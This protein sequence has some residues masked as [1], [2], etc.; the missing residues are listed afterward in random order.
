MK[1]RLSQ[2]ATL[3]GPIEKTAKK[4]YRVIKTK[5]TLHLYPGQLWTEKC[6]EALMLEA[7]IDL[8]FVKI[9]EK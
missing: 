8:T 3:E 1:S 6:L 4:F 7:R 9:E 2:S 5:N